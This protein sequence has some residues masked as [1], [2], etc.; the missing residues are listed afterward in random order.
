M[1]FVIET[2]PHF[3]FPKQNGCIVF[4]DFIRFRFTFYVPH[5]LRAYSDM[6]ACALGVSSK[7]LSAVVTSPAIFAA[8]K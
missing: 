7:S 6:T 5:F 1:L 8:V 2:Y 4:R 3:V